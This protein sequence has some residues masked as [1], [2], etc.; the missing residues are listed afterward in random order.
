[1]RNNIDKKNYILDSLQNGE[2]YL[3]QEAVVALHLLVRERGHEALK[4][5]PLHCP[6]D[7][8][9]H[10]GRGGAVDAVSGRL[11][12]CSQVD[13]FSPRFSQIFKKEKKEKKEG[14]FSVL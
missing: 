10:L 6:A 2:K 8:R 14:S 1:M 9:L 7:R 5:V 13:Y 11:Q 4:A 12:Q 3:L